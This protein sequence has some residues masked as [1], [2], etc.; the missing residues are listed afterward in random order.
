MT[1]DATR[2]NGTK[3]P[4]NEVGL[5]GLVIAVAAIVGALSYRLGHESGVNQYHRGDIVCEVRLDGSLECLA[6]KDVR[7]K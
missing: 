3:P 2:L 1:S 7:R 5:I 6:K 4:S